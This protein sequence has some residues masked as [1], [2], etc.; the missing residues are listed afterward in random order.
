MAVGIEKLALLANGSDPHVFQGIQKLPERHFNA[1]LQAPLTFGRG[2]NRP[3][4]IIHSGQDRGHRPRNAI[5]EK[6]VALFG[7][8]LAEIIVFGV[9]PQI[10]IVFR[11]PFFFPFVR[12]LF[13]FF[14][15][16]LPG[17]LCRGRR[18]FGC[19]RFFFRG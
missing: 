9:K 15:F 7:G 17:R 5:A 13:F 16:I 18:R 19:F 1:A 8:A 6:A 12:L 3:L 4:E 2:Q 14:L 10:L 11:V